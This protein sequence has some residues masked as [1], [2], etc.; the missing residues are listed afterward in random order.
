MRSPSRR[1]VQGSVLKE[2]GVIEN[3]FRFGSLLVELKSHRWKTNH[4]LRGLI[5]VE[6][7]FLMKSVP[8]LRDSIPVGLR[9]GRLNAF[10]AN[11][12]TGKIAAKPAEKL[13]LVER[14]KR[15]ACPFRLTPAYF[16]L[17]SEASYMASSKSCEWPS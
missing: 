12:N 1:E 16:P 9:S 4:P 15:I 17:L 3:Q 10:S 6:A 11:P 7:P 13:L 8:W 14:V 5:S 2:A